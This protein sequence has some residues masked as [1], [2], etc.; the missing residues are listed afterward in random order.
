M[1]SGKIRKTGITGVGKSWSE[2]N[3]Y[4]AYQNTILYHLDAPT[5]VHSM[6]VVKEA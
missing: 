3:L 4:R 2:W 6:T 1:G 5:L